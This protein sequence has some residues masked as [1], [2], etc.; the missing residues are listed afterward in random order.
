MHCDTQILTTLV[1]YETVPVP[2][3]TGN[4]LLVGSLWSNDVPND[5][6]QGGSITSVSEDDKK[7]SLWTSFSRTG[8]YLGL[9]VLFK[10]LFVTFLV[11]DIAILDK[12]MD[13]Y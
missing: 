11:F 7:Q 1:E 6:I 4:G 8:Y 12:S 3:V 13:M 10:I 5:I 9:L 2:T